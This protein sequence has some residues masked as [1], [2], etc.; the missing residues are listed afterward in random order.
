[1]N[2]KNL[3]TV[4]ILTIAISS[5]SPIMIKPATAQSI[6]KPSTPE[7]TV[8]YSVYSYSVQPT[9]GIDQYTGKN[10]TI[11]NGYIVN[12]RTIVFTIKNQPFTPYTD[13]NG[14]SI[15]L[16]YNFR[17]KG[18]FGDTWSYYPFTDAYSKP[19]I[20]EQTTHSYGPYGGGHFIYYSASNSANTITSITLDLLTPFPGGPQIPDGSQVDFQV[21]TQI[22]QINPIPSGMLA[23]DFYNFTGQTSDWSPTQTI[24]IGETAIS[25]SSNPTL[26]PTNTPSPTPAPTVPEFPSWA[27]PLLITITLALAGLL[28]YHKKHNNKSLVNNH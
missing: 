6:P 20:Q 23:G 8:Q 21:Q 14:N 16:Y 24:T 26:S 1:M 3:A 13:A 15:G 12:N 7:F 5:L 9:Y 19:N 10:V 11:Q 28:V 17:F 22:G 2:N 25:A 4:L 27:I 18:H